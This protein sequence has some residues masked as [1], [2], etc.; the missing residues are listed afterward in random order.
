MVS[1]QKS[2]P[3][4]SS[5]LKC[6]VTEVV[7]IDQNLD[8][9]TLLA[10][11]VRPNVE[12]I[13]LRAD[14]DGMAQITAA[15]AM[16]QGIQA[17]HLVSPGLPGNIQLGNTWLCVEMLSVFAAE[18]QG[19]AEALMPDAELLLYGCQIGQGERGRNLVSCLS[20]LIGVKVAASETKT[21]SAALEG[22]WNLEVSTGKIKA[23]L[24][25]APEA[26]A[27][28]GGVL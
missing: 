20:E 25:L 10:A 14:Q 27:G 4:Q 11:G 28:Y 17:L 19:W 2:I 8:D 23:Q 7:F 18:L 5:S 16:R 12:A 26:M 6:Q 3:S 15:L 24:A 22:N 1:V 9:V 13:L 21:G